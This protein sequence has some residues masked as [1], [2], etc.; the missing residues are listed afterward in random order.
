MLVAVEREELLELLK[1]DIRCWHEVGGGPDMKA[2]KFD[3]RA[4]DPSILEGTSY[5]QNRDS[6]VAGVQ[7]QTLL[8]L[9][10]TIEDAPQVKIR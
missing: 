4:I 9:I 5:Y 7:V 2:F 10:R 3:P 1:D 8:E 6:W